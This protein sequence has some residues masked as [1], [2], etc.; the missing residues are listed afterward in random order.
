MEIGLFGEGVMNR[1][2]QGLLEARDHAVH[3]DEICDLTVSVQNHH[4]FK[5][6]KTRIINFHAGPSWY[7]GRHGMAK[8][9]LEGDK[10]YGWMWH[11][12]TETIDGGPIIHHETFP[13]FSWM[14]YE[15]VNFEC[16]WRGLAWFHDNMDRLIEE[17]SGRTS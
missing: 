1:A 4:I 2:V 14:T 3:R 17:R 5:N 15:Q 13:L 8:A 12:V 10:T 6:I 7:P 16:M 11:E 9:L